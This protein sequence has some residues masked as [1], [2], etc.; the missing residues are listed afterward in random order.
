MVVPVCLHHRNIAATKQG[1]ACAHL[2]KRERTTVAGTTAK[3]FCAFS[4]L[5]RSPQEF[6]QE[7]CTAAAVNWYA[8]GQ[9]SHG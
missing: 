8:L 2:Q 3:K 5:R 7:K 4:A 1:D 9:L 6:V